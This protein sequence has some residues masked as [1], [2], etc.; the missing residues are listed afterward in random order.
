MVVI[1]PFVAINKNQASN[2]FEMNIIISILYLI[3]R[4]DTNLLNICWMYK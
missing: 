3:E 4:D 2:F 1:S